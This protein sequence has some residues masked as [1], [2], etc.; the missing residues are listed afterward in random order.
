MAVLAVLLV[1]GAIGFALRSL[2]EEDRGASLPRLSRP[3]QI[4]AAVGV[5]A[6]PTWSPDG[7]RIAYAALAG[8]DNWDVWVGQVSGGPAVNLTSKHDDADLHPGWSPDGSEIA[9]SSSRDGGGCF[10]MPALGGPPRKVMASALPAERLHPAWSPDGRE[11]AC[12]WGDSFIRIT[13]LDSGAFRDLAVPG[14]PGDVYDLSW[15]PDG[16]F[17]ALVEAASYKAPVTRLWLMRTTDGEA[18]ALSDGSTNLW[19]PSFH[20]DGSLYYVSNAGGAMD[21]WRQRLRK[22]GNPDGP[23]DAVTVALGLHSRAV[24][25]PDGSKLAY[26]KG[27][28]VS[29]IWRLPV[30][31]DRPA[32]WEDGTS[33]TLEQAFIDSLDVCRAAR[34]LV[35]SSDRAGN[36]DLW[37]MPSD[38]GEVQQLT[39]GPTSDW[40]PAWSPDCREIAFH[41]DRSGNRDIWVVPVEPGPARQLTSR[42]E[43]ELDPRWSPDGTTLAFSSGP[44]PGQT[45]TVPATG[46]EP[47]RFIEAG[48]R[49][50]DWSPDGR[51]ILYTNSTD[52]RRWRWSVDGKASENLGFQSPVAR[53]AP[54]GR[55]IYYLSSTEDSIRRYWLKDGTT[56]RVTELGGRPGKIGP[57]S[58][59]IDETYLYF[60]WRLDESDIWVM[61]V[62]P[63]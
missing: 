24:F 13:R 29:N 48:D 19:G 54:D 23:P 12:V 55:H 27:R 49:A 35:F 32:S 3:R 51:W 50:D 61:D 1:A 47:V 34:R 10:V 20:S 44:Q 15:S 33:L 45:W 7:S 39:T 53:W 6:Y 26:A 14:F 22:N 9:F 16:S 30:L 52:G 18:T 2:V 59:A 31:A 37:V 62:L 28:L 5:E 38:G 8:G 41:S 40:G 56:R 11:L 57:N 4:T 36:L 21:L 43:N 17:F 25:S 58:L 42:S 46:G 63:K 60:A